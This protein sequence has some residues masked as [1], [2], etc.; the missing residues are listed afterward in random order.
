MATVKLITGKDFASFSLPSSPPLQT[1]CHCNADYYTKYFNN[2]FQ[3]IVFCK[4]GHRL[5]PVDGK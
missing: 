5:R 2:S 4:K 3:E 1:W